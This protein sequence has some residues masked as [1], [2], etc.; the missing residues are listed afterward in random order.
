MPLMD[1]A[2]S[3]V[4]EPGISPEKSSAIFSAQEPVADSQH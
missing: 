2:A 3:Q 4:I 1:F